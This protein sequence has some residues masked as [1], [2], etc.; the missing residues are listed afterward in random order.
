MPPSTSRSRRKSQRRE[1]LS[2]LFFYLFPPHLINSILILLL[3]S[4]FSAATV[5]LLSMEHS[6]PARYARI[7]FVLLSMLPE[8]YV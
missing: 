7:V 2:Q 6:Q 3:I 5:A 8:V 1:F 4:V